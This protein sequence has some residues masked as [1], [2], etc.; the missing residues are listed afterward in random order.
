M[1]RGDALATLPTMHRTLYADQTGLRA[2]LRRIHAMV[3]RHWYLLRSSGPRI[4]EMIF[5]PLV[6]M[7]T[8]GFLQVH[9]SKTTSLG[10]MAA[11]L[12]VG[13]VLLW[14]ILARSQLGFALAFLEE[15]WARNLGHLMMSPLRSGELIA[16]L[17]VV[18]FIKLMVAMVPVVAIAYL[19]FDYSLLSLGLPL[20]LFFM[21]L[22]FT[23]WAFGLVSTG[24]VLRY[25]LGAENIAWL[26]TFLM[27][28]LCCVYYPVST[29]PVWLQPAAYALPPTY[30]F[31]G[32]RALVLQGQFRSDLMASALVL[33]FVYVMLGILL[34]RT[35]MQSAR[36]AG[37][38][39]HMGE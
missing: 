28:P 29:L 12:F 15:V 35:L 36:E 37:T 14:D 2:S 25:G 13:G 34:F 19:L 16:S 3:L 1:T 39:V 11:G 38:L 31:E 21:N 9:L 20:A 33:N 22:V 5:W 24:A 4:L 27:M 8:W 30:V 10:A 6:Q 7:M 26:M 32:M 23:S 17:I 18:S